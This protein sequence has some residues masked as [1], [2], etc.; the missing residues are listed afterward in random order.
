MLSPTQSDRIRPDTFSDF[1]MC[2]HGQT[3]HIGEKKNT[4]YLKQNKTKQK[5]TRPMSVTLRLKKLRKEDLGFKSASN[6]QSE[7]EAHLCHMKL[8]EF[9]EKAMF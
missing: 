3:S 1:H 6:A 2:I 9:L 5:Q 7:S 4:N 8:N